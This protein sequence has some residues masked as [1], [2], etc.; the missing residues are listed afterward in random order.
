MGGFIA[1][2]QMRAS[3]T[4]PP[5]DPRPALNNHQAHGYRDEQRDQCGQEHDQQE[6]HGHLQYAG[7]PRRMN[8]W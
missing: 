4:P 3:P 6:G 2:R 8:E 1:S 7:L 5:V